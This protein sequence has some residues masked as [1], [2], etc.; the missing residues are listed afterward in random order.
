MSRRLRTDTNPVLVTWAC[1][2]CHKAYHVEVDPGSHIS[3]MQKRIVDQHRE[4][5]KYCPRDK[6]KLVGD[7][8]Y[9]GGATPHFKMVLNLDS[10]VNRG[11][12]LIILSS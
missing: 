7:L 2:D 12:P 4:M 1:D 11:G 5:S 9:A 6:C 8:S 10:V 3:V